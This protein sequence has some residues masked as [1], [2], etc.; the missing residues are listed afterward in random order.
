MKSKG[1]ALSVALGCGLAFGP[2]AQASGALWNPTRED[3]TI[4]PRI[5]ADYP[6]QFLLTISDPTR[7]SV[8]PKD[9]EVVSE[10]MAETLPAGHMLEIRATRSGMRVPLGTF[11]V[12][13][14]HLDAGKRVSFTIKYAAITVNG[15]RIVESM[16][17]VDGPEAGRAAFRMEPLHPSVLVLLEGKA[18]L[19]K[20][21]TLPAAVSSRL[22]PEETLGGLKGIAE[23]DSGEESPQPR[24]ARKSGWSCCGA[25]V[26]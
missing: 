1:L 23:E 12:A 7:P 3:W 6:C 8:K 25:A 9:I 4:I 21:R 13:Y 16:T 24:P 5:R 2:P 20:R 10:A 26:D 18:E 22:D 14:D 17:L 15:A 11:E 19:P